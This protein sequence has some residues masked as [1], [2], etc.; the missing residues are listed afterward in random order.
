MINEQA[1]WHS[2]IGAIIAAYSLEEKTE[3]PSAH[4]MSVLQ[5]KTVLKILD[6]TSPTGP[7]KL[8]D[9][10]AVCCELGKVDA[11]LAWL[12]GVANAAWS[13][14][15]NF[16]LSES[17]CAAMNKNA[18]LSMV[19]GR[20]ATLKPAPKGEGWI[21]NGEWKY[22]S[23]YPWSSYFFGLAMSDDGHVRVVVVPSDDLHIIA[24]WQSTGLI[25]TQSVT[26]RAQDVY[27]PEM[28]TVE[29]QSILSGKSRHHHDKPS[30]S[31]YFT[32]VLMNCLV[33][34]MLG[35]TEGAIN[36]V[37]GNIQRPIAGSTYAAMDHSDPIRYELGRLSSAFDL[38]I[39][40][41]EYNA[42]VIDDAVY[43]R[44]VLTN[45]QRVEI[46]ARATQ[47]MRGCTETV[48]SLLWLYGSSGL[49]TSCPLEKIWRD[50]NVGTRHG[51]F[52]K[53]VPEELA[54]ITLLGGDPTT[55]SHMF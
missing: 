51:G 47:I 22:A 15:A 38:L 46:R 19:L 42:S 23:G 55:L 6:E 2:E 35:A 52:A 50:I 30:Y 13:M 26:I 54:G 7:G 32:G 36:Y 48:Q 31:S 45:R 34:S 41:A 10:V 49:E 9:V 4:T 40:A 53:L 43:N 25:G 8:S 20:P 44:I 12:V 27:V 5:D 28:H 29:Y 21:L 33:G 24:P 39:R 18:M 14:R 17:V 37:I 11:S 3:T 16:S 1:I